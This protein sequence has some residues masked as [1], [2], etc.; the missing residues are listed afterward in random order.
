MIR[1]FSRSLAA[2]LFLCGGLLSAAAHAQR[3]VIESVRPTAGSPG[4]HVQI[5]GRHFGRRAQ[6][7]LGD[8]PLPVL[9]R[10][11]NRWTVQIPAGAQTG[12]LVLRTRAGAFGGPQFRVIAARPAPVVRSIEPGAAPPGAEVRLRGEGF[13]ARMADNDVTLSGQ[14]VVVRSATPTELRVIVPSGAASGVFQVSVAGAAG[15]G[16][17]PP[18]T[19]TVGLSIA[20]VEPARANA[21]DEVLLRGSGFAVPLRRNRV[22]LNGQRARGAARGARASSGFRCRV[23]QRQENFLSTCAVQGGPS[24]RC[25][26]SQSPS[27]SAPSSLRWGARGHGSPFT[28]AASGTIFV[29]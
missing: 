24:R 2:A 16:Q 12:M 1:H 17:S 6:F 26:R 19:V 28:A 21:G 9:E 18:L 7:F 3:P 27:S 14:P 8:T 22:Y 25:S 23:A 10:L 15:A 4:T 5:L 20:A 13:S 29:L 11:P